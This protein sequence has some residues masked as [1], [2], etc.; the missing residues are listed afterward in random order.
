MIEIVDKKNALVVEE[1]VLIQSGEIIVYDEDKDKKLLR[2]IDRFLLPMMAVL[3]CFQFMDKTT[4]S[5]ASIMGFRENLNMKGDMYSWVGSSFY[6]GYLIFEY[7]AVRLLQKFPVAKTLSIFIIIWGVVLALHA[8]PNYAGI[9]VLR[10]ALGMLES[11]ITPGFVIITGQF[12]R[13]S[14]MFVR[15]AIW[16]AANGMGIILG[17]TIGY[18][19]IDNMNH[20]SIEAWKLLFIITGILTI[21]LGVLTYFIIPDTPMKA[22]WLTD[23]DKSRVVERIRVNQQGFGNSEFKWY[24]FKEAL[25]DIKTWLFFFFAISSN[26]PN[27]GL[28][29]FSAILLS[30]SMGFTPKQ[31]L[32]MQMPQGAVEVVGCIGLAMSTKY[33]RSKMLV[34]CIGVLLTLM[35]CCMLAFSESI[36]V[37]YA[38]LTM[39]TFLPIGFICLLSN[40]SSNVAGHTKK[41]TVNAIFL[42]G[43]CVGNLIGPQTFIA[44]EAPDYK[45]AEICMVVF[46]IVALLCLLGLWYSYWIDNKRKDA[47]MESEAT[48]KFLEIESP[49]FADYTDK[50]NPLFRYIL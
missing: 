13:N 36:P 20:Y 2:K 29:N 42:I 27:G 39:Q 40:I 30:E 28:T 9:I 25:L 4:P 50:E 45:T 16:F 24:Q 46:M 49:E 19:L 23:E 15:T 38:G 41:T 6:F 26:V 22:W 47:E 8:A 12:Y 10:V 33:V 32:L 1:S 44:K 48:L 5:A 34:A 21:F 18:S 7:P 31:S 14:E 11:A 35:A 3:Y 43:Y 17:S 37:R